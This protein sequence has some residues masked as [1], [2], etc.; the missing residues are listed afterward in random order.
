MKD[1]YHLDLFGFIVRYIPFFNFENNFTNRVIV[2]D[3]ELD[4]NSLNSLKSMK[5]LKFDYTLFSGSKF[6]DRIYKNTDDIL[7]V[8]CLIS[9][10]KKYDKKIFLDL[11]KNADKIKTNLVY[12]MRKSTWGYGIDEIFLNEIFKK[13][14][15]YSIIKDYHIGQIFY[16]SR[17][18]L[19]DKSRIKNSYKIL[20]Q[21]IDKVREVDFSIISDNPTLKDMISLID[22]YTFRNKQK[23]KINDIISINF[24]KAINNALKTNTEFL[25]RNKMIFISKYLNNV[26]SCKFV[27]TINKNQNIKVVDLYDVI[28]NSA[29]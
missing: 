28:Y 21:I 9:I 17:K 11:I 23:T 24:Y 6:W 15:E 20:K 4:K 3:I 10:T 26:I 13:K 27:V 16:R 1:N 19:F 22:K 29:K 5:D 12:K 18:Y 14:I 8:G 2:I 25:E 7:L